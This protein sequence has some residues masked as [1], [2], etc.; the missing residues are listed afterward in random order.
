MPADS[1]HQVGQTVG[2]R[3]RAAR[4]ARKYTQ[5]QLARPDFSVSYISAIERGQIQ[6]SLRALEIL[7]RRLEMSTTDLLPAHPALGGPLHYEAGGTALA[8]E[9][10]EFFLLEAQVAIY[11]KNPGRAR[12]LLQKFLPQ[13]SERNQ[14][15]PS[16]LYYVL[17]WASLEE[18][19]LPESEQLLA[20]AAHL[21][22]EARDP[23]YPC[24]LGL[25]NTVYT[26][27]HNTEQAAQLQCE[28]TQLLAHQPAATSNRFFLA[29]LHSSLAHRQ[30]HL[31]EFERASQQFQQT[32]QLLKA[33]TSYQD[34]QEHYGCLLKEYIGKELYPLVTLYSSKAG[35]AEL[36]CRLVNM[37]SE[38][39]YALGH[40][41]LR[42]NAEEAHNYVLKIAREAEE[43]QDHLS[44]AGA[45]VQLAFWLVAHSEFS[46]AEQLVTLALE[47]AEPFGETLI[48]AE[49]Q[50]LAGKLAYGRQDYTTG[51]QFFEAGLAALE[52]I[53]A[54]EELIEHFAHYAQLLETRNCIQK[55]LLYWKRAFES[56]REKHEFSL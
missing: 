56:R 16:T 23:W 28:S 27:L 37:R 2:A 52:R 41:L 54:Q 55:A 7:A 22:R 39:E 18:G 32:L 3:L 20:E 33:D 6:P 8:G 40:V 42:S 45:N 19:R 46:Q 50:L 5:S 43:R 21:A 30:S 26:A 11:Q 53:G 17:G 13:K 51:D 4:I 10:L 49:G 34:L 9:E 29:R 15:L 31:G 25:Q 44:Q 24:I 47:Q 14:V 35:L 1:S 48:R 36:L 38:I 12:E